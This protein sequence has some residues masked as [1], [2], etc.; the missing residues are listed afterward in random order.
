MP[1][2]MTTK[3]VELRFNYACDCAGEVECMACH[4]FTALSTHPTAL[5][6]KSI[7]IPY[8]PYGGPP[9]PITMEIQRT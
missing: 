9:E 5:M 3:N 1:Y 2:K 6:V 7:N 8:S 4:L